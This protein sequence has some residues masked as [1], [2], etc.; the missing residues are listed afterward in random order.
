MNP[1]R[2]MSLIDVL[3]GSALVLVIFLGLVGLLRASLLVAGL[4]KAKA[5]ATAIAD[6]QVEYV[7]ALDYDQVGTIGGI[8][9]GV[10]SATSTQVLNGITYNVRTLIEY[11][12]DEA[13]GFGAADTNGITTD[14][15]RIK[16]SV[17]YMVRDSLREVVVV[18]NYAP[19]AVETTT[20]GGTLKIA[21][22]NAQGAPV[23]GATVQVVNASTSPTVNL[24]TFSDVDG[25]VQ[26]PGAPTSTEY[27]ITVSKSGYSSAQTY[28]RDATNQNPAPGYLTVVKSLTTTGTFAIDVL[29][30]LT[31][32]TL[33]PIRAASSTDSFID[34]SKIASQASTQVSGG[35]LKLAQSGGYA[36]SGSALTTATA[37]SYLASWT[38]ASSTVSTP[39][40]TTATVRVTDGAGTPLSDAVLPGNS[41]GFTSFPISLS[42]VSTTTYPSLALA[43]SLTTT[44][45]TTT[46]QVLDWR[47]AYQEGPVPVPNVAFTL[48]GAKTIGSTGGGSPIYKTTVASTTS[49]VGTR[50]MPLEWDSYKL[51]LSGYDVIDACGAPPFSLSP[52]T[53]YDHALYLGVATTNR[54]LVTVKDALG[55]PVQGATVT[56]SKTGFSS[57]VSSSSCGTAY[58][59]GLSSGTY[60]VQIAKTGYT[61][62]TFSN[63]S[64]SGHVFYAA[65]FP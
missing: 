30:S 65:T 23:S 3:V 29:S 60:S 52:G 11:V 53:A 27:R 49:S 19:P 31:L 22:V 47:V 35:A 44:S 5:G 51:T 14:Y 16:V 54:I 63:V 18:S 55:V 20:N 41:A 45:T 61:T 48:T 2:G 17:T 46:S 4:A 1:M 40:G 43:F 39:A 7:R 10:A 36:L 57:S 38:Y 26:L 34:A 42:G 56:V 37:P 33:Y 58:F 62:T 64:I 32:R 9:A 6:N 8:P 50:T 15:K 12:D 13:D 25:L 28:A 21:V 24:S 59:G